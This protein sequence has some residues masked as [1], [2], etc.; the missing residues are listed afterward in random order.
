MGR[1]YEVDA[2]PDVVSDGVL[3]YGGIFRGLQV[4][5]SARIVSH[6][7]SIDR[8]PVRKRLDNDSIAFIVGN[9]VLNDLA[10]VRILEVDAPIVFTGD[11]VS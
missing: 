5:A 6:V 1:S 4:N 10:L 9:R 3:G 11:I 2:T 7:V 8:I